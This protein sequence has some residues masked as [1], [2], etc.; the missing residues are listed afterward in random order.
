MKILFQVGLDPLLAQGHA[1]HVRHLVDELSA[2]GHEIDVIGRDDGG[3]LPW[4]PPGRLARVPLLTLPSVRQPIRELRA[5]RLLRAW[6][7]E[8]KYDVVFTRSEPLAFA[9]LFVP[10]DMPLAVESNS[11]LSAHYE[12][13]GGL[14]GYLIRRV[15]GALLRRANRIG[16]VAPTLVSRH[17]EEHA[18]H[19]ESFFVVRNGAVV[20]EP[21]SPQT[22]RELREARGASERQFVIVL[23][24]SASERIEFAWL[25][26]AL[27]DVPDAKLW[28]IGDGELLVAWKATA[29]RSPAGERIDFLGPL[30]EGDVLRHIQ[31][32][33]VAA[34]P[35]GPERIEQLGGDP[36][37]VLTAMAVGTQLLASGVPA[38]P[39]FDTIGGGVRVPAA[40]GA[41]RDEIQRQ[42]GA[43]RE[44]GRPLTDWPWPGDGPAKEWIRAHRSWRHAATLW[45]RELERL[46][47]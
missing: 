29:E 7:T 16:V 40:P 1:L 46:A 47:R 2:L 36:L 24:G 37:K 9:P 42:V 5:A 11:S 13:V 22:V 30:S 17:A 18:I 32:A 10:E 6:I 19:P 31:A 12:E 21:L 25:V 43:W 38:D 4:N 8:R 33:Q 39:P 3:S 20:P 26:S 34:A 44:S 23:A 45:E 15:E 35:Y 14:L 41:W 27:E 28:V